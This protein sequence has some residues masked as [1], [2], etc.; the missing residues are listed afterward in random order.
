MKQRTLVLFVSLLL[1][2][3]Y[4]LAQMQPSLPPGAKLPDNM[5]DIDCSVPPPPLEWGIRSVW[6]SSKIVSNLIIPLVGDLNDDGI[7]EIVCFGAAGRTNS[8]YGTETTT[9]LVYNG[10]TNNLMNTIT[11]P[12]PVTEFDGAPFGLVKTKDR[13]GLII[14]ASR[15]CKLRAYDITSVTPN[16]PVWTSDV[17][18]G[19]TWSDFAVNIGFAD[20]NG[21]GHPE[22]YVRNKIYDATTGI[23]LATATGGSNQGLSWTHWTQVTQRRMSSPIAA[24]MDG[25][26]KPE[27]ILGNQIYNVNI[28]NRNGTTSNSVTLSKTITPPS[29]VPADGHAQAVDFNKDGHLDLLITTRNA[30]G[31]SGRVYAY[32]WDVYNNVLSTPL[33]I[34]TDRSGKSIPLI[35][36]VDNDG[37]LEIVIQCKMSST[38]ITVRCYKYDPTAMTFSYLWGYTPSEDSY[39]NTPTLFDF[40]QDGINEILIS[41]QSRIR[42]LDGRN[43][44]IKATLNF[45]QVTIMQYP[46]IADVDGDGSADIIAV[47]ILN[48]T[49]EYTGHLNIFKSSTTPW[50]PARKVWNQY[51]YNAVNVNEDLTIPEVQFSPTTVFSGSGTDVR[52]FNN[53]L[54]Q[55]TTLNMDGVP[56]WLA[57]NGQIV[58][59]PTFAYNDDTNEM[60]VTIQ[61]KNIGSGD[62]LNPFYITAY[63]DIVGTSSTKF[64]YKYENTIAI[65]EAKTITF[66]IPNF[67]TSWTPYNFIILKINDRGNGL[68]DQVVCDDSNSQYRYYGILPT[69]QDVC[70]GKVKEMTCSFILSGSDTYQWQSSKDNATWTDIAGAIAV[71]YT[72]A[73]QKRGVTYYRVVVT[74]ATDTETVESESVRLRVRSCQLP[75][76]HNISVMGY[77]D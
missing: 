24:D 67:K 38:S 29:G 16:T 66:S 56:F 73:N 20:F 62:F 40:N 64:T 7:P 53:Y 4:V 52:P 39:S 41:D 55:Q 42:I 35:A 5:V 32:V 36:D 63:K 37:E 22:V 76:N 61:V 48:G 45:G 68:N 59:T 11:L 23:L 57:A 77:Y 43:G 50:A 60:V 54:Q 15:D 6:S 27:L 71:S 74:N 65:G 75:V 47:G 8:G 1:I 10:L 28:V 30:S 25:D 3:S 9:M 72:P 13:K 21:D 19:S 14:V 69:Q 33:N 34:N 31:N 12:S 58:G 46:V 51:M 17:D 2:S 70:A 26:G 44:S 18:Y 49:H